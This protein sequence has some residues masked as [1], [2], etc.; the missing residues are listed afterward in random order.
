MTATACS[1]V[2]P[3]RALK[4]VICYYPTKIVYFIPKMFPKEPNKEIAFLNLKF[5]VVVI[6]VVVF[7]N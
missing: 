7:L 1:H 5:F 6:V 3:V 4:K 2:F